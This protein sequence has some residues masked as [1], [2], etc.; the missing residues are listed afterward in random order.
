MSVTKDI[1]PLINMYNLYY[2]KLNEYKRKN[3]KDFLKSVSNY[4]LTKIDLTQD[5]QEIKI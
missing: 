4:L 2:T 3:D 5:I 1:I